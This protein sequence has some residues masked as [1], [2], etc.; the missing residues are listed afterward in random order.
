VPSSLPALALHSPPLAATPATKIT[1]STP[2]RSSVLNAMENT[3]Y[4][5]RPFT[6]CVAAARHTGKKVSARQ[7]VVRDTCSH[8]TR[9]VMLGV[10][11]LGASRKAIYAGA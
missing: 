11:R 2:S 9:S 5:W 1:D 3:A 8:A 10:A 6:A 7:P 4:L